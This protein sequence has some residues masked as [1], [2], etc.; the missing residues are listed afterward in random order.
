MKYCCKC[1]AEW[2]GMTTQPGTRESCAAC[3][4]DLHVCLNCRFYDVHR[5]LQCR[6]H[7][8]EPVIDKAK[9]NFCDLFQFADRALPDKTAPAKPTEADRARDQWKKL[10]HK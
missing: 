4:A 8:E 7:V 5:P 2:K 6:E 1:F 3:S 9:A 10:F